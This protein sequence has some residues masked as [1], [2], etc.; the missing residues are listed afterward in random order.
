MYIWYIFALACAVIQMFPHSLRCVQVEVISPVEDY[1]TVLKEVFDFGLLKNFLQRSDFKMVFDAL[2]AVT[3][4]YA[5]PILVEELGA[6]PSSIRCAVGTTFGGSGT[7]VESLGWAV[8]EP[9]IGFRLGL[10]E[11]ENVTRKLLQWTAN[12]PRASLCRA[13]SWGPS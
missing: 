12:P 11:E 3:G 10:V 13:R 9:Y 8:A 6:D 5:H 1:L 2:H 7:R 4:A